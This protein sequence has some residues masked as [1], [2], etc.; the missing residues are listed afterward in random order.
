LVKNRECLSISWNKEKNVYATMLKVKRGGNRVIS[1]FSETDPTKDFPSKL[2]SVHRK[3]YK[4]EG[5]LVVLS[6]HIPE[7]ICFEIRVPRVPE[8]ELSQL[9]AFEL[10]HS[11]PYPVDA[12]KWGFRIVADQ[13]S[14]VDSKYLVRVYVIHSTIWDDLMADIGSAGIH[15]DAIVCPYFAV[16]PLFKMDQFYLP[17]VD[18]EYSFDLSPL[19]G[20]REMKSVALDSRSGAV[21]AQ[22]EGKYTNSNIDNITPYVTSI[23]V[24]NYSLSSGF[25]ADRRSFPVLNSSKY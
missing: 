2:F 1:A 13:A 8:E 20:M 3:L 23:V 16:D 24:G 22:V 18:S 11:I 9:V 5:H 25:N 4:G 19:S 17:A 12:V 10:Q 7:S 15:A 14:E 6:G 21:Y